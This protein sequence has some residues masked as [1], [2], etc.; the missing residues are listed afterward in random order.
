MNSIFEMNPFRK[1][2]FVYLEPLKVLLREV[3]S[4][5]NMEKWLSVNYKWILKRFFLFVE[6]KEWSFFLS[7]TCFPGKHAS[8]ARCEPVPKDFPR[9]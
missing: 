1:T 4:K 9:P 5:V 6:Q 8:L 2:W 7:F 3:N